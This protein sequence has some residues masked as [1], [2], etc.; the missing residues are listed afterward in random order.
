MS[1]IESARQ[2]VHDRIAPEFHDKRIVKL[3]QLKLAQVLK[4][5]NPYLFR[6]I[7]RAHV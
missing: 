7:G 6:E 4:R 5:K 3:R 2:Y 1:L